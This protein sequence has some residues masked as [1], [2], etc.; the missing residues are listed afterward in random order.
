MNTDELLEN[1][2]NGGG[3]LVGGTA[4]YVLEG[5]PERNEFRILTADEVLRNNLA[6]F[7]N[8]FGTG[9]VYL[10]MFTTAEAAEESIEVIRR[11][12][13]KEDE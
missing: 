8:R 12:I 7:G 13:R 4:M 10:G 2:L 3:K 6:A 11:L 5:H 9:Y 1:A